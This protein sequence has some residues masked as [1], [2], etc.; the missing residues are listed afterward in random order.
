MK[1]KI[2]L[3]TMAVVGF[4]LVAQAHNTPAPDCNTPTGGGGT[5]NGQVNTIP[6]GGTTSMLLG[7][8]LVGLGMFKR[9]FL[10]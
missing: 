7:G 1:I 6:D 10:K 2:L 9:K 5:G 4:G 8:A 3:A